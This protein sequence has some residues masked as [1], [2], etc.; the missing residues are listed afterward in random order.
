MTKRKITIIKEK[1]NKDTI[2]AGGRQQSPF[3]L[4]FSRAILRPFLFISALF[5]FVL[6][7]KASSLL[8]YGP[9]SL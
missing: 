7:F 5:L 9:N 2:L 6:P 4:T 1:K 8:Q 3:L